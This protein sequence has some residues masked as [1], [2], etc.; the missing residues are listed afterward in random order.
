[1]GIR[2][3][4]PPRHAETQTTEIK[5]FAA[6]KHCV[7]NLK[8]LI[9]EKTMWN[10]QQLSKQV[11]AR[12]EKFAGLLTEEG[13]LEMVARENGIPIPE[14]KKEVVFQGFEAAEAGKELNFVARV[15]HVFA[16][17]AFERNGRK[18]K[19]CNVQLADEKGVV[20]ALVLWNR[21]CGLA[22]KFERGQEIEV[23]NASVKSKNPLEF[24][25][26]LVTQLKARPQEQK[27]ASKKIAELKEGEEADFFGR[28]L[29]VG[30]VKEFGRVN[31]KTGA[32]EKGKVARLTLADGSG[33]IVVAL[34]DENAEVVKVL[35]V[36]DAVKIESGLAKQNNGVL[37]VQAGWKARII[38]NPPAHG[39]AEREALWE[40][41]FPLK[42]IS[43][44]KEGETASIEAKIKELSG[45]RI[46][47]KC[48]K[49]GKSIN[50]HE[51]A[52]A[53]G[54]NEY[55]D[56]VMAEA[57][58]VD[59]SGEIRAVFFGREAAHFLGVESI[60]IDPQTIVELK[61][62]HLLGKKVRLIV[63][64]KAGLMSGKTE[65]TCKHVVTPPS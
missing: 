39:L 41:H 40:T 1:M 48:K 29:D 18:G 53:C 57:M 55:R 56:A 36:G 31:R 47:R 49:C 26:T 35:R 7:Q 65:A 52:C 38:R 64:A 4:Q 9:F 19:V 15:T 12:I 21:D 22:D 6:Q 33:R 16:P 28:V 8:Q 51:T 54:S 20:A 11:G 58:L 60:T 27:Q 44:L 23:E 17:K 61:K 59:D 14:K 24:H 32:Q 46:F 10:E 50:V 34:W 63:Q 13:A 30:E 45:A 62:Q 3:A 37:E 25:A 2:G 42:K 43:E 5:L